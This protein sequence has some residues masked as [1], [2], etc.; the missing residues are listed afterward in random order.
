MTEMQPGVPPGYGRRNTD[1]KW[2][3]PVHV[4]DAARSALGDIDLDPASCA[5]AQARVRARC[6]IGRAEDGTTADWGAVGSVRWRP[7]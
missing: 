7:P 2:W 5:D 6:W 4:L 1:F 3:T